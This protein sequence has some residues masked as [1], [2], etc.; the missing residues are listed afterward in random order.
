MLLT[1]ERGFIGSGKNKV[2][3]ISFK[4]VAKFALATLDHPDARNEVIAWGG[5]E[6]LSPLEVVLPFQ[7]TQGR[8]FEVKHVPEE[9]L[10][11]RKETASLYSS[12]CRAD[13]FLL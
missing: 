4:D 9:E 3:W 7:E 6:A 2:S 11:Q 10:R 12:L 1:P 8:P 5:P 13:A